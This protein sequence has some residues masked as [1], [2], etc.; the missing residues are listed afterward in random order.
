MNAI[1]GQIILTE[2]KKVF[3][4]SYFDEAPRN[5]AFP[6]AVFTTPSTFQF[7]DKYTNI[8]LEINIWDNV[9]DSIAALE[10]ATES[11]RSGLHKLQYFD[12]STL[13]IFN[14]ESLLHVPDPSEQIRRRQLRF[15][16]K[17]YDRR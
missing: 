1:I 7:E 8:V 11:I 9:G 5:T 15:T 10:T 4:N 13:L 17:Y 2:L 14:L 12:D 3:A 6:F 16:I